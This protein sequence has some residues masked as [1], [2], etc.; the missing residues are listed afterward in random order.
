MKTLINSHEFI[1]EDI[2][3]EKKLMKRES[4]DEYPSL[5]KWKIQMLYFHGSSWIQICRLDNYAHEGVV[6][7]HVHTYGNERVRRVEV[8]FREA[9][10]LLIEVGS[11]I[12]RKRFGR[13]VL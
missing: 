10:D 2:R 6:G 3:I 11:R 9:Y 4:P 1:S 7:S 8:S 5:L 12:L 13:Y